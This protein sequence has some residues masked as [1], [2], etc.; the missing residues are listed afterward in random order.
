[1]PKNVPQLIHGKP[2]SSESGP[3]PKRPREL[4][5]L[6][7]PPACVGTFEPEHAQCDGDPKS[8]ESSGREPCAWRR[9]CLGIQ[10]YC[11]RPGVSKSPEQLLRELGVD[12]FAVLGAKWADRIAKRPCDRGGN[13][14]KLGAPVHYP[15]SHPQLA[16]AA[17]AFR[18]RFRELLPDAKISPPHS[19]RVL[20]WSG[21][22]Y[23]RLPMRN[24][25]ILT[26]YCSHFER[27]PDPVCRF[28]RIL[29]GLVSVELPLQR[30]QLYEVIGPK[31]AAR[32]SAVR[33]KACGGRF[34]CQLYG[35]NLGLMPEAAEVVAELVR[36]RCL[37]LTW[38]KEV[39]TRSRREIK[40]E[41]WRK[42]NKR[43][44]DLRRI[45]QASS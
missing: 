11:V 29:D 3:R 19:K 12:E 1:M 18:E 6:T 23:E 38:P 20:V 24:P 30:I 39:D 27:R 40:I 45:H 42:R 21:A 2:Q 16:T 15:R 5:Q 33:Y 34:R 44:D 36:A 26:W 10:R 37:Q 43:Y 28:R 4:N 41:A 14:K 13:R 17:A 25:K 8:T 32:L 22:F 9:Y 31:R 35:L 7:P